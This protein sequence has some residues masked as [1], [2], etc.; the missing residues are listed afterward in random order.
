MCVVPWFLCS[1]AGARYGQGQLQR[2]LVSGG[3]LGAVGG[4]VGLWGGGFL[5]RLYHAHRS[6][7]R[8]IDEVARRVTDAYFV[9]LPCRR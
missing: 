7:S 6:F 4:T 9:L 1:V 5:I 2:M 3:M 8:I